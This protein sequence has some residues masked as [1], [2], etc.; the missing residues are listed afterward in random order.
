MQLPNVRRAREDAPGD[1]QESVT[2]AKLGSHAAKILRKQQSTMTASLS[3]KNNKDDGFG[4]AAVLE[5]IEKDLSLGASKGQDLMT[6]L[7]S[8][9]WVGWKHSD[10]RLVSTDERIEFFVAH[11][12]P[13][14]KATQLDWVTAALGDGLFNQAIQVVADN[15][16]IA[17]A[18]K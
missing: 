2:G 17:V 1:G 12:L 4:P 8:T 3:Y 11:I 6:E 7:E 10:G 9:Q 13:V 18:M 14:L 15:Q 5:A 16:L